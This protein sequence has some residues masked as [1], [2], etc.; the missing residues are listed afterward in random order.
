MSQQQKS[1]RG[2][3]SPG[4]LSHSTNQ[5]EI[6]SHNVC[7]GGSGPSLSQAHLPIGHK[8]E[9]IDLFFSSLSYTTNTMPLENTFCRCKDQY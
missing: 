1:T 5:Q 4:R 2:E 7:F 9:S 8:H 3:F 6:P